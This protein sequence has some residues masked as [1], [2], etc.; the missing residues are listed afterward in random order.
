MAFAITV[1][2]ESSDHYIFAFDGQPTQKE[3]IEKLKEELGDEY[4]WICSYK[5]DATY[6]IKFKINLRELEKNR[7]DEN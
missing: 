3:I 6:K 2:T 5:H 1:S 4:N 7:D